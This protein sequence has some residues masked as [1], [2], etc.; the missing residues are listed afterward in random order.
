MPSLSRICPDN[1]SR[2]FQKHQSYFLIFQKNSLFGLGVIRAK[3]MK[4]YTHDLFCDKYFDIAQH[5]GI[6]QPDQSDV[7]QLFRKVLMW[8]SNSHLIFCFLR[9]FFKCCSMKEHSRYTIVTV[10][11]AKNPFW[12]KWAIWTQFGQKLC[13]LIFV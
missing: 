12:E 5:D 9:T 3:M 10:N 13:Y 2:D 11:F 7:G 6:R 8:R 4:L 1:C